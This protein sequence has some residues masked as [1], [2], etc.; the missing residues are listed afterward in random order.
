[1]GR[2]KRCWSAAKRA[3]EVQ[4]VGRH[5]SMQ[6][7][8]GQLDHRGLVS[9]EDPVAHGGFDQCPPGEAAEGGHHEGI[10]APKEAGKPQ[11][12][13]ASCHGDAN[14]R[15]EVAGEVEPSRLCIGWIMDDANAFV[16]AFV[17]DIQP[18][19]VVGKPCV[20]VS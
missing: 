15:V 14:D 19:G 12:A 13:L 9:N 11:R 10:S 18:R 1:M 17:H 16:D 8:L 5:C 2:I 20:M 6:Q 4:T 7:C 3:D